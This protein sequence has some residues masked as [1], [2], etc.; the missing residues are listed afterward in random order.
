MGYLLSNLK[1]KIIN[2]EDLYL[3]EAK[4]L[5]NFEVEELYSIANEIRIKNFGN[6]IELCGIINAKSGLCSENC[7]FCSQSVHYDTEV[8]RYTLLDKNTILDKAKESEKSGIHCFSIVTSGNSLSRDEFKK[9]YDIFNTLREK[10]NLTL[11]A[12][13]GSIS[14]IQAYTLRQIGVSRYHHNI[15]TSKSHYSNIC[16]SHTFE[17]R[18]KTIRNVKC[19]GFEVCSGG[20]IGLGESMEQRI[21][22]ALELKNL[23]VDSIP[24][25]ILTPIKGTPLENSDKLPVDDILKS[26]AIFRII[27]QKAHIRFAAG[28][29][30]LGNRQNEAFE[31]GLDAVM[32]G[33]FLTTTGNNLG[34]DI[35]MFNELG[36]VIK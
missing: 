29:A 5:L 3:N 8:E 30:Q 35:K 26:I 14:Y 9:V 28:R 34:D 33:N 25:N 1:E 7:K 36:Y 27:N 13:L 10:T 22:M 16:S 15:E 2:N 4:K 32:V 21:E 17:D 20:I 23:Q 24:I 31:A 12:S 18:I 6:K 11:A 19:A